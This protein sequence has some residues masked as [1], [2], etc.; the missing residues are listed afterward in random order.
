MRTVS[1][2]ALLAVALMAS[3]VASAYEAGDWIVR[4]GAVMVD[5]DASSSPLNL[6][7]VGD[8]PGT[9]VD[10]DDDT[11]LLL[12]ITYMAR[13]N[14]GIELLAA[15]PFEHTVSTEGL[16]GLGLGLSDT[17]LADIKHLPPTLSVLWYPMGS[18]SKFQPFIGAGVNYTTFF[19]EDVSG[20]ARDALGA[21]NLQLDDSWGL[22]FRA[23][24]DYMLNDCWSLHAGVYYIDISTDAK[25][26]TALGTV[27]TE[28][29]VDPWVYTIG[30]GYKF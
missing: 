5:P 1:K 24:A 17:D 14:I 16:G 26:E 27:K 30:I 8:L 3:G 13:D 21:R 15:T 18:G 23:G 7:G 20:S 11:Q 6:S 25:V 2:T 22:A 12:N 19:D 4:S 10:V 29:D 9:G 28:V